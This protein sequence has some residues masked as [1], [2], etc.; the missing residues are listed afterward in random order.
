MLCPNCSKE[1][2][3]GSQ[4]CSYCG[5]SFVQQ[6]VPVQQPV[7][8]TVPVQTQSRGLSGGQK[9]TI[10][11]LLLM[12]AGALSLLL[13]FGGKKSNN[14]LGGKEKADT[15]T[16]MIYLE[17]SN[18]ES[19][20]G[21]ATTDLLSLDAAKIDLEKT[22]ILIY[23][24]GTKKWHNDFVKNDENAIFL[25]TKDGYKKLK[26]YEKLNMG[27]PAT[28]S[29][30]MQYAYENYP[31]GHYNLILDDHGAGI[32]GAIVDD[33][34]QDLLSLE[35][36]GT[37]MKNS[38]FNEKNKLDTVLFR[39]CLNGTLEVASI[40]V[41]YSEYIVFSEEIS[42]GSASEPVLDF[43]HDVKG[44]DDGAEF[45]KHYITRYQKM[46]DVID[47]FSVNPVTYSIVDLS[48]VDS[49]VKE[50]N[51]FVKTVD[52]KSHYNSI[53]RLRANIYQYGK[54]QTSIYDTVDLYSLVKGMADFS[55]SNAD[56]L[57]NLIKDAVVMNNTNLNGSNGISIYFPYNGG[58]YV[59]HFLGLYR[60]I[61]NF[62]DYRTFISTFYN[63][64]STASSFGYDITKNKS[65]VVSNGKEVSLQLT[66]EQ[67][68]NLSYVLYTVFKRNPE[69][70]KYFNMVF[71]SNDVEISESGLVTTKIGDRL[72]KI[73][74]DD[75][76][77]YYNIPVF[78]RLV[79]GVESTSVYG[80]A[81]NPDEKL[82]SN[83]Y[84]YNVKF[85]I[86][87]KDK[88]P[89]I[90]ST[91]VDS[92]DDE[93][94]EGT[95]LDLK[96][97]KNLMIGVYDYKFMDSKGNY[98]GKLESA[99]SQLYLTGTVEELAMEKDSLGDGE[100]YVLFGIHDINDNTYYSKP[101]K[102][103]D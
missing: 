78:H 89:F 39:T 48:K 80:I 17:G 18:L 74:S 72:I 35:D 21:I 46:I 85:Q 102:V 41:P 13:L 15:R 103:G 49:I 11:V 19:D 7:A 44:S 16:I 63:T 6:P 36:F 47:V 25:F 24:G 55:G 45:G 76:K 28:L 3:E 88:N 75:S 58:E 83:K 59:S 32:A 98:L 51:K 20:G 52:I 81:K 96:V 64:Q 23:T 54:A 43:L 91:M 40:F 94:A 69:H 92:S 62:D 8:P 93:R 26:T 9:A 37:A 70:P 38:P 101:I 29:S 82:L 2:P 99:N 12:L 65:E 60:G 79:D 27:D 77:K 22:N 84:Q 90:A 67:N 71:N 33:F 42:L 86:S 53:A 97:Y 1:N 4:F 87:Y 56:T 95:I 5:A 14:V 68:K 10:I 30:F 31:A 66:E 100:Y 34:T 61:N 73:Y 57:L 50:L